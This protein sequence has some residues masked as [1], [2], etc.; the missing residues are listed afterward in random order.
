MSLLRPA[1]TLFAALSLLTGII[2]PLAVTALAQTL[3]PAQANGSLIERDGEII[4][5]TLIGQHFSREQ[6][7]WSRPSAT[8]SEPYNA[9]ASGGSNLGP[10]NPALHDAVKARI[11]AIRAAHPD[12]LGPVPVD[13]V[14]SSASGLDPHLSPAAA[15]FQAA[16]I[17]QARHLPIQT[18]Q[19]LID[20][21]TAPRFLGVLGEPAIN[22]L[23]L[24]LALDALPTR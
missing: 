22:V 11:A 13:L 12:Q 24:N 2:Y 18:V 8:S 6:Y 14:T 16:R 21:H 17:A 23:T 19:S 4:G 20:D 9:A 1:L 10:L 7:F 3:F 5:S 15:H